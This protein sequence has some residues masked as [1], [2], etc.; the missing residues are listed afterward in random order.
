MKR[1]SKKIDTPIARA[2]KFANRLLKPF[3]FVSILTLLIMPFFHKPSWCIEK[4]RNNYTDNA[5]K[6]YEW[7]G[8]NVNFSKPSINKTTGKPIPYDGSN[9]AVGIPSG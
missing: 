3:K 5:S 1:D 8:F 4:Y 2:A 6:D 7:C 9:A